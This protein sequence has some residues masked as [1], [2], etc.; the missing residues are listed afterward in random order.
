[1]S[2]CIKQVIS[3]FLSPYKVEGKSYGTIV[4]YSDKLKGFQWY[5]DNYGLPDDKEDITTNHLHEF[6]AYLLPLLTTY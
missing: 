2:I 4:C 1:M 6:L 3:E 5:C